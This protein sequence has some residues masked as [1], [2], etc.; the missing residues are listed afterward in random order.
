MKTLFCFLAGLLLF[1]CSSTPTPDVA[2]VET[3]DVFQFRKLLPQE[4]QQYQQQLAGMYDSLLAKRSFNGGIIIAKNG[5]ILLEEYRGYN[6]LENKDTITPATTFHLASV[7]KTFTGMAVLRLLQEGKLRLE[8]SVQ[9]YFPQF[10]YPGISVQML[11]SHRS[12]LP[13]YAY[14]MG[15]DTMFKKRLA[16]NHDMLQFMIARQPMRYA[17]PGK[18]FQYCNTNYALLALIIEKVTGST[19]PEYMKSQVFT[20]L[21]MKN[22]FVFSIKDTAQYSPS[23]DYSGSPIGLE[24]M[25]C[26]YGDKNIYST[27][28][29]LLLW[30]RSIYNNRLVNTEIYEQAVRPYSLERPSTHNYGLGWRLLMFPDRKVVYHN[31]WW[32]GNNTSFTRFVKDTATVIVLGN[33]FNRAVYAG[34]KF[35]QA[36][37]SQQPDTTAGVE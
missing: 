3:Q 7:S 10:P 12:G 2:S 22:T 20:P 34:M 17:Q 36:F 1:S 30:D 29:D 5:E 27:P 9:V 37:S 21:G 26:I 32:H 16:T 35:G 8:D 23:Y 24:N 6:N 33:R 19:Y 4:K 15:S 25:D 18:T 13:N 31:G 14:F 11:L 28:R